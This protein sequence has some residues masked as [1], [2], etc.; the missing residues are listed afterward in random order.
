VHELSIALSIIEGAESEALRQGSGRVAAVHL[1]LGPLSGVVREA[2]TF[3]YDLACEGTALEGSRL[4]VEE[5]PVLIFCSACNAEQAPVST[6]CFR[7][8]V[9]GAAEGRVVR[10]AELEL[11]ALELET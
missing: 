2:L 4:M 10:G 7:C 9:C 8:S 5:T 11:V 1:K 6:Q 3:A